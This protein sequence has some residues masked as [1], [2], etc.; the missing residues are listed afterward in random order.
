MWS[1][2]VL[3]QSYNLFNGQKNNLTSLFF[4]QHRRSAVVDRMFRILSGN[5]A[6]EGGDTVIHKQNDKVIKKYTLCNVCCQEP[7]I[8]NQV[9]CK[10][11]NAAIKKTLGSQFVKANVSKSF[12]KELIKKPPKT[13]TSKNLKYYKY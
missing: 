11:C 9:R 7:V 6:F 3:R 10:N 8:R 12:D 1:I 4:V 13:E 5:H 2:E